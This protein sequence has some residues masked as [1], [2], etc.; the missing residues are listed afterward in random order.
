MSK[1][2]KGFD[3]NIKPD[4]NAQ[5]GKVHTEDGAED[6][7]EYTVLLEHTVYY[8]TTVHAVDEDDAWEQGEELASANET[9]DLDF[10]CDEL[11][12]YAVDMD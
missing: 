8:K 6:L 2:I 4:G 12:V 1:A 5:L 11:K 9:D 7:N 10:D 3:I